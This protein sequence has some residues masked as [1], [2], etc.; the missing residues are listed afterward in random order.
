MATKFLEYDNY[1]MVHDGITSI[2]ECEECGFINVDTIKR[3]FVINEVNEFLYCETI[4]GSLFL[5]F[6]YG[7]DPEHLSCKFAEKIIDWIT[8]PE[9]NGIF[10]IYGYHIELAENSPRRPFNGT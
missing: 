8:S 6:N 9:D 7:I 4:D 3:I 1:N 2:D 10:C 5:L